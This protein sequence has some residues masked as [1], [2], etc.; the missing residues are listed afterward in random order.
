MGNCIADEKDEEQIKLL[1]NQIKQQQQEKAELQRKI[2]KIKHQLSLGKGQKDIENDP[3]IQQLKKEKKKIFKEMLSE[4]KK[5]EELKENINGYNEKIQTLQEELEIKTRDNLRPPEGSLMDWQ[6]TVTSA[7]DDDTDH[8]HSHHSMTSNSYL[9]R[10]E[11]H[12]HYES[13]HISDASTSTDSAGYGSETADVLGN[14][15]SIAL[16]KCH[17]P[18]AEAARIHGWLFDDQGGKSK[19]KKWTQDEQRKLKKQL[20]DLLTDRSAEYRQLLV[21]SY[22]D[23]FHTSLERD[24]SKIFSHGTVMSTLHLLLV[25]RGQYD[26]EEILGHIQN[27][28]LEPIAG[29][30]CC[31]TCQ[32]LRELQQAWNAKHKNNLRTQLQALAKQKDK[33]TLLTVF[34]KMMDVQ[35][36][37]DAEVDVD[38]VHKDLEF[39]LKT[40]KFDGKDKERLLL[41]FLTNSVEYIRVFNGEFTAKSKTPLL[42][43]VMKKM[44]SRGGS[45]SFCK[46]RILYALDTPGYYA[47]R[48]KEL[49]GG[50][51]NKHKREVANILVHRMEIDLP[52]IERKWMMNKYGGKKPLKEVVLNKAGKTKKAGYYLKKIIENSERYEAVTSGPSKWQRMFD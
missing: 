7:S 3:K 39:V 16:D 2:N 29:I 43:F 31:R 19:K 45:G 5:T 52:A 50:R 28:K 49:L 1:R 46:T 25:T 24:I 27:L 42:K 20:G 21:Q 34:K 6:L 36:E 15:P 11:L 33:K 47:E 9:K 35:R 41:I 38:K 13:D 14:T 37:E 26:A 40:K 44:K 23:Q 12:S 18:D 10:P 17:E 8:E 22:Q 30:I 51:W 32:E 4:R 48:L